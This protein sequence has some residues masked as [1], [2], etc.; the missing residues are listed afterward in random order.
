MFSQPIR[1]RSS[2]PSINQVSARRSGSVPGSSFRLSTTLAL[3]IFITFPPSLISFGRDLLVLLPSRLAFV[4][5]LDLSGLTWSRFCGRGS[6]KFL[7]RRDYRAQPGVLPGKRSYTPS[8]CYSDF[9]FLCVLA[10]LREI[11]CLVPEQER[12]FVLC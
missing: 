11:F 12:T 3:R 10:S 9:S 6:E 2:L 1:S 4:L 8:C 5:V 7:S